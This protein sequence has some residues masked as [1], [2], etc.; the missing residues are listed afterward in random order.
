MKQILRY[1]GSKGS[2]AKQIVARMP[3]HNVYCEPYGGS[4]AVLLNKPAAMV[5]FY[6]DTFGLVVEL[7]RLLREN[8]PALEELLR[9][10]DFTPF[11]REELEAARDF[12]VLGNSLAALREFLIVS[13]FGYGGA[14]LDSKTGWK[15]SLKDSKRLK[16]W[17]FL[18]DRLREAALRLKQCHIESMDAVRLMHSVDGPGTL[19]YVDPPY[20]ESTINF[21]VKQV[22]AHAF[23]DCDH[24]YLLAALGSL[25]GRV[26]LSGYPHPMYDDALKDWRVVDIEHLTMRNTRK[27]E[28]L[29]MNFEARI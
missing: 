22:Y 6:N 25:K 23:S 1:P 19:H 7:F 16:Q 8:G 12:R 21:K 26:I 3:E 18:P 4:A 17:H 2:L 13:W 10:I 20:I 9:L 29:W 5:E 14:I 24:A 28:R 27:V 15:L 11:A